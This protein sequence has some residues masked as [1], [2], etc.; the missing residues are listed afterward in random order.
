VRPTKAIF[1]LGAAILF[2]C[3]VPAAKFVGASIDPLLLAGLLY[4]GSGLG[5]TLWILAN[6]AVN[7]RKPPGIRLKNAREGFYLGGAIL[8]GG[9]LAPA[10]LMTGLRVTPSSTASL[11][12]NLE[13]AFT[14][15]LACLVFK[16]TYG[17]RLLLGFVFLL[18]GGGFLAIANNSRLGG[19]VLGV[20]A[21]AGAC[22]GWAIDNNLTKQVASLDATLLAGLKGIVAGA[23]NVALALGL[24]M[25]LPGFRSTVTTIGIGFLGYGLS[26]VLYIVSLRKIGAARTSAYFSTAPFAGA[27]ISIFL[28]KEPFVWPLGG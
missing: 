14:V 28:L 26:L 25:S 12:L 9:I 24:G 27:V 20:L 8:F 3:S 7:P 16:E 18:A 11:L 15:A 4:L 21:I 5:L 17:R 1:A 10:L 2:G 22:V 19:S 23:V 6:Y 13:T